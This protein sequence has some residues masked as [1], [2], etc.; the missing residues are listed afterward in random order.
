QALKFL[1]AQ[2]LNRGKSRSK[3][4][5]SLRHQLCAVGPSGFILLKRLN[6]RSVVLRSCGDLVVD[7]ERSAELCGKSTFYEC[8]FTENGV[9]V[10][11][12]L[13]HLAEGLGDSLSGL[14][15]R[16]NGQVVAIRSIEARCHLDLGVIRRPACRDDWSAPGKGAGGQRPTRYGARRTWSPPSG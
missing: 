12:N 4:L 13:L 2:I 16:A 11:E 10:S 5:E 6:S 7:S 8:D 3:L 1:F 9:E 15:K 14:V